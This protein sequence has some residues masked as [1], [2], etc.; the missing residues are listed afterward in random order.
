[1]RRFRE[2]KLQIVVYPSLIVIEEFKWGLLRNLDIFIELTKIVLYTINEAYKE[3]KKVVNLERE[4]KLGRKG[5]SVVEATLETE[6][7]E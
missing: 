5:K 1:M 3:A 2:S 7:E 4:L 6:K